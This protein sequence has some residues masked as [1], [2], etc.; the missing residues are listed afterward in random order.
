MIRYMSI[1]KAHRLSSPV[2]WLRLD[3]E[4][5]GK[6]AG[7]RGIG[8]CVDIPEIIFHGHLCGSQ[9]PEDLNDRVYSLRSRSL[10]QRHV[11]GCACH[12]WP[13]APC[14][15]TSASEASA[16]SPGGSQNPHSRQPPRRTFLPFSAFFQGD[17]FRCLAINSIPLI[18][19]NAGRLF[20]FQIRSLFYIFVF[21]CDKRGKF[22]WLLM[23]IR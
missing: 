5:R 20:P 19:D 4:N 16:G 11:I 15:V 8:C 21:F 12:S 18:A 13:Q 10:P 14:W 2:G 23:S 1:R 3:S 22:C 7:G 9:K 17:K 6:K